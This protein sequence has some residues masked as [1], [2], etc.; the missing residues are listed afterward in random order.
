MNSAVITTGNSTVGYTYTPLSY[1]PTFEQTIS[2]LRGYLP[3]DKTTKHLIKLI[4]AH[5]KCS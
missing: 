5:H 4:K 1:Y 3:K 2:H